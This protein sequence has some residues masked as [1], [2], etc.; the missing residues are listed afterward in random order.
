VKQQA[1]AGTHTDTVVEVRLLAG[2]SITQPTSLSL[3]S[4]MLLA[5]LPSKVSDTLMAIAAAHQKGIRVSANAL[6]SLL[7]LLLLLLLAC[8]SASTCST[9]CHQQQPN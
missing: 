6:L 1:A 4:G 8:S 3:M 2:H 7:L 5:I 9:A